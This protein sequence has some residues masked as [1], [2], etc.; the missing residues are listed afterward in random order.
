MV[1]TRERDALYQYYFGGTA[2]Q[3]V[4]ILTNNYL[5]MGVKQTSRTQRMSN[6]PQAMDSVQHNTGKMNQSS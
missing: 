6:M 3:I 5:K 2:G 1:R 4:I